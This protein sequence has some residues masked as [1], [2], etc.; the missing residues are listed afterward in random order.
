MRNIGAIILGLVAAVAIL[1]IPADNAFA[2]AKLKS[3]SPGQES[4]IQPGL[5][6]ILLTFNEAVEAS[7]STVDLHSSDGSEVATS[8]GRKICAQKTCKLAVPALK[9]GNYTVNYH[10]LSVDGHVV[11]GSYVFHVAD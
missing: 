2:H 3:A 9:A 1:G 6:E 10:I 11:D 4:K 8:K 5:K 7:L